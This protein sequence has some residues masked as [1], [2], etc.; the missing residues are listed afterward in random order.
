M[1]SLSIE[2][3]SINKSEYMLNQIIVIVDTETCEKYAN[4]WKLQIG[5]RFEYISSCF[6]GQALQLSG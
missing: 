5:I 4:L 2:L 1:L 6:V 3:S